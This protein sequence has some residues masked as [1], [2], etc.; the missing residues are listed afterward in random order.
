[1]TIQDS[2]E[3]IRKSL[4]S[5]PKTDDAAILFAKDMRIIK[6][7]NLIVDR[8]SI[9]E[10]GGEWIAL[11]AMTKGVFSSAVLYEQHRKTERGYEYKINHMPLA[12]SGQ[13]SFVESVNKC[14]ELYSKKVKENS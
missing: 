1:M 8:Y 5:L 6:V 9:E 13:A 10:Y 14:M 3:Q 12:M 11:V 7:L 2:P 4:S